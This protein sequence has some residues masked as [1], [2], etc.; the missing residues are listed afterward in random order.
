MLR[1][2]CLVNEAPKLLVW[3]ADPSQG[4]KGTSFCLYDQMT[5]PFANFSSSVP[6]LSKRILRTA[7]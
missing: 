7:A 3:H 5:D 4:I 2:V 6:P 1:Q